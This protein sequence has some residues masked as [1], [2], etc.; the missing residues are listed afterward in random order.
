MFFFSRKTREKSA[1]EQR[2]KRLYLG[3]VFVF[4]TW[5]SIWRYATLYVLTLFFAFW[6]QD[7]IEP[8]IFLNSTAKIRLTTP[9]AFEYVSDIKTKILK[10]QRRQMVLPVYRVDMSTFRDFSQKI[11]LMRDRLEAYE[12]LK[13]GK[14]QSDMLENLIAEF[15]SKYSLPLEKNDLEVLL[16][17]TTLQRNRLL[18]ESLFILQEIVQRGIFDDIGDSS[19]PET[20]YFRDTVAYDTSE[21]HYLGRSNA[22]K[23]L[24]MDLFVMDIDY[25]IASALIHIYKYGLSPN[26]V[27]DKRQTMEKI[28]QF[29]E[30]TPVVKVKILKGSTI[31]ENGQ[32]VT[33]EIY[34]C[35]L[36]YLKH[37]EQEEMYQ[38]T[39]NSLFLRNI[40]LFTLLFA[41]LTLTLKILP[42][43]L[44]TSL[45]LRVVTGSILLFNIA[46]IRLVYIFFSHTAV[47]NF[48]V[49]PLIPFLVPTFLSSVLITSLTD[50]FA[51]FIC[52]F[53]IIGVKTFITY[54]SLDSFF[55][56][57]LVGLCLVFWCRSVKF[58]KDIVCA[59]FYALSLLAIAVFIYDFAMQHLPLTFILQ[60]LLAI[61]IGGS[62]TVILALNLIPVLEKTFHYTTN[63]TFLSLTD[64][65][66]PLLRKLQILA[67]G[68]YHHSLM[69]A[70]LSE[71][72]ASDVGANALLCR[73]CALYHDIG[74]LAKPE[75]FIENQKENE[76]PHS[77]QTPSLSAIILKSHIKEGVALA[78]VYKLPQVVID[79]I[80]QH[81]G[82]SIMKYFYKKALL[83][84]G[85]DETVDAKVF[86]YDGPKPQ[87]KE[88][89]IISLADSIEAAS[90][91]LKKITPQSIEELI[92]AIIKDRIETEQ[93]N[94]CNITFQDLETIRKSIQVTLLSM[95]H[96]RIDYNDIT[97]VPPAAA[98]QATSTGA[99]GT[100][101]AA[102]PNKSRE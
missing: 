56:D 72:A 8:Q 78:H 20:L 34:E 66:H 59:S 29:V 22:I 42:T 70:A 26:L 85:P 102:V 23:V 1:I 92:D 73:C 2:R 44:N 83:L 57:L 18:D 7:P 51:G 31:V 58:R 77:T 88:S 5:G 35:Y 50:I 74:K 63:I 69:V 9:F 87:F 33:P 64:Y 62:I 10:N 54:G 3:S 46:I 4:P 60:Q 15:D 27:Y 38:C 52:T 37:L 90:R 68:T 25:E 71:K 91:T 99:E 28:E 43:R 55:L 96:A 11:E 65:N 14:E 19:N 45:H 32:Q 82:T 89:A 75:Y 97:D 24:R 93:L 17:V 36:A 49:A 48:N 94:E 86:S 21:D 81:H 95:M 98:E 39:R 12:S 30:R 13:K 79:V 76:N 16:N 53:F 80:Q 100:S 6:K 41:I 101:V 61:F 40:F 47:Q 67:P 84:K